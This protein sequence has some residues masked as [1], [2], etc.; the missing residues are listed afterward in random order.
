MITHALA[1]LLGVLT[2]FAAT[3]LVCL[4]VRRK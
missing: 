1:F 4:W 3:C 2:C